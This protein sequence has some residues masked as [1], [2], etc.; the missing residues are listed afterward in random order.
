MDE[1]QLVRKALDQVPL[2]EL[3]K[4]AKASKVPFGT[5]QKIKYG[6]TKNPRFSTVRKLADYFKSAV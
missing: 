2:S 4:H 5:L 6:T 1:L 3:P